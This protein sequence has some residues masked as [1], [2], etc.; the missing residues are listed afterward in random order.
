VDALPTT[1]VGKID[2][3]ALRADMACRLDEEHQAAHER[4]SSQPA[5]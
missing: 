3:K 5:R 4:P 1:K 2:K